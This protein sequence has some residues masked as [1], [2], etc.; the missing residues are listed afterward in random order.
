MKK[1]LIGIVVINVLVVI[2]SLQNIVNI[3]STFKI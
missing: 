3:I 2:G 1:I